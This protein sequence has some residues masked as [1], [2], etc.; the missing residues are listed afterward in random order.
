[1]EDRTEEKVIAL[2]NKRRL[3]KKRSGFLMWLFMLTLVLAGVLY[4]ILD[5]AVIRDII[6]SGNEHYSREEIVALLDFEEGV[7]V[8]DVYF[9]KEIDHSSYPY[10]HSLEVVYEGLNIIR[11]V[12]TE[13]EVIS[14]LKYQ[15]DYLALD[16]DG[17]VIDYLD[18]IEGGA[19]EVEGVYV[20]AAVIGEKLNVDEAI[21]GALLDLH[22]LRAKYTVPLSVI[23]FPYSDSSMLIGHVGEIQ[24]IFGEPMDL[25]VKMKNAS[26]VIGTLGA[27]VSGTLDL[28][29][30]KDRFIFKKNTD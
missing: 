16:K 30:D 15:S 4:I 14:Y 10:I 20:G 19:P 21:I 29:E 3:R 7:N 18:E 1:M 17:Y 22:H 28:Q 2:K 12:V 23:E 24:I 26:E 13:K 5:M 8:V 25:D 9:G 27:D 6:V 11:V